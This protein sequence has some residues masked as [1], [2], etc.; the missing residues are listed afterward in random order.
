M[1]KDKYKLYLIDLVSILKEEAYEARKKRGPNSDDFYEG[2]LM[3]YYEFVSL[4]KQQ[5]DAF[6]I[7][8]KDINLQ[9]FDEF[10]ELLT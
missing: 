4:L 6:G 9:D 3:A 7:D 5:A 2:R 10:K 1:E 8:L